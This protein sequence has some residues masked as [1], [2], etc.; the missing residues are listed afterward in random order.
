MTDQE[1]NEQGDAAAGGPEAV[2]AAGLGPRF[3]AR[4][5][6]GVLLWLVFLVVIVPIIV[7]AL[8]SGSFGFGSA[9]GGGFSVGGFVA[10]VV[11]AAIV[12]GYV[13]LMESSRGQTVG[14]MLLKL[15]TEGPDGQNPTLEMAVKRNLWLALGIIP[16]VGGLAELAAV[17]YIAVTISQSATHTGWHDTFG[18]GT[19]VVETG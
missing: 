13:A 3:L 2:V 12:V 4:L 1:R 8:F 6:D 7:V 17:V 5:I 10:G 9:F 16:I 19:R 18:G 11:W 15:R 14:K